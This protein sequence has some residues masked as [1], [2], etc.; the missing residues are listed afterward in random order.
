MVDRITVP[1]FAARKRKGRKLVMVTC[2]DATFARLVDRADIDAVLVGDSL[3]NVIQGHE[4]TIPVTIEDVIYHTRAVSRGLHHP[5]L[6]AD[7]PFMTYQASRDEAMFNS[8]RLLQEGRAHAVKLEGGVRVAETVRAIVETGIPVMGHI[9]LTPQSVH[10]FGGYRIQGRGEAAAKR[11]KDDAQALQDAGVFSIVL[12]GIPTALAAE[13][14]AALEV[15]T[16]GIGAGPNCDGQVLVLYD[17]LGLD[18][19]FAPRFV[20]QYATLSNTVG[21][22][23]KSFGQE[24][25][26]GKFPA[27]EHSFD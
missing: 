19:S 9:G 16:I 18:E 12:E 21:E 27:E 14:S 4:T 11:L 20:K 2:Y 7:L 6:V 23:L 22:A 26:D 1:K 13:I 3:G 10:G 24:V 8:G 5:L 25:R 15:P 17:L